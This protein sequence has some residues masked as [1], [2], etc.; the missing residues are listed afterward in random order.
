MLWCAV[1]GA[2]VLWCCGAVVCGVWSVE[3]GVWRMACCVCVSGV[4]GLRVEQRFGEA[5]RTLAVGNDDDIKALLPGNPG[6]RI[7]AASEPNGRQQQGASEQ[8]A[9]GSRG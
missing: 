4:E 3:C 1:C 2:V 6:D 7:A 8:C 9:D 5:Y